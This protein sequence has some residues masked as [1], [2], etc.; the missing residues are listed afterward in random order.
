[1]CVCVCVCVCVMCVCVCVCDACVCVCVCV[2]VCD[3]DGEEGSVFANRV[4]VVVW[5]AMYLTGYSDYLMV[6]VNQFHHLIY[7][8]LVRKMSSAIAAKAKKKHGRYS[9]E[10]TKKQ[11]CSSCCFYF[12][13]HPVFKDQ[14]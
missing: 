10:W 4:L 14:F 9:Q 3:L 6:S 2:C 11:T 1:M 7:V 13:S 8:T 5:A 12:I